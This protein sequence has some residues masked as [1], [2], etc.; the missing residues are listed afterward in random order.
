MLKDTTP[1]TADMLLKEVAARSIGGYRF[2]TMTCVDHGEQF[3]ILYHF[4]KDYK[5]ENLQL[6]LP[7]GTALPS[8]TGVYF[9]AVIV[10]NEMQ[11]L[12]G[13]TVTGLVI[14][15][16]GKLLLAEGAPQAPLCKTRS[17]DT[18]VKIQATSS[19]S[20]PVATNEK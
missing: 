6:M 17:A 1:I 15:Y 19:P 7:K 16:G 18:A 12:F 5:L 2:V 8:I 13:I 11:D 10:E 4:D 20:T 3:E 9:A 14:N